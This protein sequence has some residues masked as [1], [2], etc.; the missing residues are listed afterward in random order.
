MRIFLTLMVLAFSCGVTQDESLEEKVKDYYQALNDQ[1]AEA[2]LRLHLDSIRILEGD[3]ASSISFR[4]YRKWLAWDSVFDPTY[5]ILDLKQDGDRVKVT[6]SKECKRIAFLNRAPVV[7]RE[8]L[9]FREGKVYS[10]EVVSSTSFT[11]EWIERRE[12]LVAW[13][14]EN[15]PELNGFIHDQTRQGA[16]SYLQ[17]MELYL[18]SNEVNE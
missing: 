4:D 18:D 3:Y 10:L 16:L 8:L 5:D 12:R 13:V 11:Q 15:H 7:N 2:Y 1:D 9:T 14:N 17:A 6:V